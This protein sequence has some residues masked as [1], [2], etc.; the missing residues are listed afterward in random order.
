MVGKAFVTVIRGGLM[1]FGPFRLMRAGRG[2]A[3]QI[4]LVAVSVCAVVA[5]LLVT[6]FTNPAFAA[7]PQ[8]AR[9]GS[10][11]W[12]E[13][14]KSRQVLLYVTEGTVV[15][16]LAVSTGSATVG[17]V[18]P[19]ATFTVYAKSGKWDGPRYKPLYLRGILAIHGY[20]SVP[21]YPASH[22]CI[23]VPLWDQDELFPMVEVGTKVYVY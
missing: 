10:G 21:A 13:V 6:V 3:A 2:V 12:I 19:T 16:T 7:T 15:R 17:I 11:A 14:D 1:S 5:V 8:A 4:C 23:R 9:S 18:T 20:P 22:G